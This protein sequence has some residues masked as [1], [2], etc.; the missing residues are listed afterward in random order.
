[1]SDTEETV[2]DDLE[3]E[4]LV[5]APASTVE[6]IRAEHVA[7]L[8][9]ANAGRGVD[10]M[11]RLVRL[12]TMLP[13]SLEAARAEMEAA[14]YALGLVH[15]TPIGEVPGPDAYAAMGADPM[16]LSY[17]RQPKRTG[18]GMSHPRPLARVITEGAAE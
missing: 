9:M 16:V 6:Y 2:Y 12:G 7:Q 1:M 8:R 5:S 14:R 10:E 18:C 4:D 13:D 15:Q 3:D 11:A 17:L